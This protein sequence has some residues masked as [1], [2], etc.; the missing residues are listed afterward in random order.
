MSHYIEEIQDLIENKEW[1][2]LK[3][4]LLN[5]DLVELASIIEEVS[6]NSE[7]IIFRLLDKK[8][9][10]D[11]FSLLSYEKQ[12]QIIKDLAPDSKRVSSLL[13]EL[14]PDDRTAF[15]EELP[16]EIASR[17]IQTLSPEEKSIAIKLLGYPEN[18]IG[19]LMTPEYIAIKP[20]NSVEQAFAHIRKF[21]KDSET[22][23]VI[24]IVDD[25]QKLIDDVR[26]KELILA[27][28]EQKVEELLDYKFIFLNALDDQ[29]SAIK[30]FRDYDRVALPVLNDDGVLVG[31][32]SI[33]DI[34]DV[35][36]EESTEDFHKFGSFQEAIS[37]PLKARVFS[38]YKNRIVWLVA[39]VFMNVFSGAALA[40]FEDL[41][42]AVVP[43]VFFLPLL[44]DS[45][46]NAGSQSAT[47]MIRSLAVGDVKITD[48][49]K[50]IGREVLVSLL[51]GFTMALA[52]ALV[53]SFRAPELIVVVSL[54]MVIIVLTG[55]LIGLLLPF[56]F[57]KLKLDPATASAP[58]ITSIAD[59]SGVVIYFSIASLFFNLN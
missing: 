22:L 4:I 3:S 12:E 37:N 38:L 35:A 26:I 10:T 8:Q 50:L 34:M 39:L 20:Y 49:Y 5:Y 42:A 41:I 18:S 51:L 57:T 24:Y 9:T 53:A 23:N 7:I 30:T 21:G 43:L 52:V 29:E 13:N 14:E 40:S 44:I 55:S 48:W 58:L 11:V 28:P 47:L 33:D 25:E 56:I 46:G 16:K 17:L 27:S 36:H 1:R 54:T 15:F 45:G 6:L 32:V 31:I 59:I 2:K 19:R